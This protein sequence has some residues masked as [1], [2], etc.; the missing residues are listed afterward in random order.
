MNRENQTQHTLPLSSNLEI[1]KRPLS[2][3]TGTIPNRLAIQPMEGC[4][5]K[6]DGSPDERTVRRYERFAGS[7]A[8]LIWFEAVA[9]QED[10]R[11]NPRQLWLQD[12]N[13]DSFK[14]LVENIRIRALKETNTE[15]MIIMQATHSGRYS[16]PQGKVEPLIAYNNPLFEKDAPIP[17]ERILTD[18]AIKIIEQSYAKSTLLAQKA[19]FDGIDIKAC[20]RYLN[21]ELFSAFTREGLYGGSFE[22]RTRFFRNAVQLARDNS[23]DFVVTSRMNIYDGFPYPYGFGVVKD[24]SGSL[25]PDLSEPIELIRALDFE[26]LNITMGNPYVNP[27][28]NRPI[29]LQGVERMYSLTKQIQDR[30]PS[31]HIVASAPSFMKGDS[32]ALAAGAI[33]QGYCSLVGFGRMAFAYPQFAKDTLQGNF[34]N[35]KTCITCGKCSELMRAGQVT[36]CV[37]RDKVYTERYKEVFAL[38][39]T[40]TAEAR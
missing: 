26:L 33:E 7:G 40:A 11:A 36:G 3:S 35:K 15:P 22:N 31:L 5:G 19:G 24:R 20:H 21:S 29:Q 32:P 38:T 39:S 16:K 25:S 37:I 28:V 6:A 4:D 14:R 9:V 27:E 34:D 23:K 8:G 30:F 2:L 18:D 17:A 13:L 10:G 1:L 12:E